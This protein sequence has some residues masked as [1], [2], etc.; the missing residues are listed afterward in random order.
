MRLIDSFVEDLEEFL[1]VKRTPIS[2]ADLWRES[3]PG[4]VK[5]KDDL[6]EYLRTVSFDKSE[7]LALF[8][9]PFYRRT[10]RRAR[11][12]PY[13]TIRMLARSCRNSLMDTGNG[14]AKHPSFTEPCAGGGKFRSR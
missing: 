9:F 14:L 1:G 5:E 8:F 11:R 12:E 4:F 6:S 10:K 7:S 3:R 13:P 2:L